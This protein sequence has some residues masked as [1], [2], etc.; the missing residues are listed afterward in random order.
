MLN[1]V[2]IKNFALIK[3]NEINFKPGMNVLTGET[4]SGKSII[5]NAISIALGDRATKSVIRTGE[6]HASVI[7]KFRVPK[8]ISTNL[9]NLISGSTEEIV[10]SKDIYTNSSSVSKI[11]GNIV[12]NAEMK[13]IAN[14]LCDIYSQFDN[15][16]LLNPSYHMNIIDN[17][18]SSKEVVL[19]DE[20]LDSFE[21]YSKYNKELINL[22]DKQN[23]KDHE[24]SFLKSKINEIKNLDLDSI[25]EDELYLRKSKLENVDNINFALNKVNL[26]LNGDD[27]EFPGIMSLLRDCISQ[28]SDISDLNK[29]FFEINNELNNIYDSLQNINFTCSNNYIEDY[30]PNE[31]DDL[32]YKINKIENL[33]LKYGPNIDDVLDYLNQLENELSQLEDID[34]YIDNLAK[35]IDEEYKNYSD[36]NAKLKSCRKKSADNFEIEISKILKLLNMSDSKLKTVFQESNM[37]PNGNYNIEFF[38][39]TNKG[40]DFKPLVDI[41][42]GGELSRFIIA[43]KILVNKENNKVFIFDEIDSGISGDAANSVGNVLKN[44]SNNN[45]IILISHLPQII[46]KA[47]THFKILKKSENGETISLI[48]ELDHEQRVLE[49][50]RLLSNKINDNAILNAKSMLEE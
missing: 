17:F 16:L 43:L 39:S 5:F 23:N 45:Q 48:S 47:N 8:N 1:Y 29:E 6:N 41:I 19:K 32:N 35:K 21:R 27:Y 9:S 37:S 22:R 15:H 34:F 50:A 10:I 36:I 49:L 4:G 30:E 14:N 31:L 11:N 44:L 7:L 2:K 13:N 25:S 46:S 40:S 26:N 38:I 24:I 12:T 33:K 3:N 20:L 42:S 28:I 18:L